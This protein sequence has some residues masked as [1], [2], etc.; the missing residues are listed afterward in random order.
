MCFLFFD[1]PVGPAWTDTRWPLDRAGSDR[2][3]KDCQLTRYSDNRVTM[4]CKSD[5]KAEGPSEDWTA[6]DN[7]ASGPGL[8]SSR[9]ITPK[10]PLF[11]NLD[12]AHQAITSR[13]ATRSAGT[14]PSDTTQPLASSPSSVNVSD[15]TGSAGS[16][17]SARHMELTGSKTNHQVRQRCLTPFSATAS[18][19]ADWHNTPSDPSPIVSSFASSSAGNSIGT[20]LHHGTA[21]ENSANLERSDFEDSMDA[22]YD[23][24]FMPSMSADVRQ[25]RTVSGVPLINDY[26]YHSEA[27]IQ[28]VNFYSPDIRRAN[29]EISLANRAQVYYEPPQRALPKLPEA[30]GNTKHL[31][32]GSGNWPVNFSRPVRSLCSASNSQNLINVSTDTSETSGLGSPVANTGNRSNMIQSTTNNFDPDFVV[33]GRL[34]TQ[35][36]LSTSDDQ[37]FPESDISHGGVSNAEVVSTGTDSDE[38]PFQY[39]RGSF[40]AFLQPAREREVSVAL[41]C[42]SGDSTASASQLFLRS[43][44]ARP[45][46]PRVVG[47]TNPFIN[48]LQGYQAPSVQYNWDDDGDEPNEI[49]ISI[50]SSPPP[51]PPNSPVQPTMN[52]NEFVKE[53]NKRCRKDIMSDGADWETVAATSVGQF[54]SNRAFASSMDLGGGHLIKYAGSS[55]ADYSDTSSYHAPQFDAFGSQ[56]RIVPESGTH[57]APTTRLPRTL[58]EAGQPIF[59]PKPRIHR[60]N[61]YLH[62]SRR[63]FTD[64]TAGSSGNSARSAIVE[65]LSASIRTRT[66]RKQAHRRNL[67]LNEKNQSDSRFQSMESISST[68]SEQ[69]DGDHMIGTALECDPTA[70]SSN[71]ARVNMTVIGRDHRQ[72]DEDKK[73]LLASSIPKEPARAHLKGRIAT[74]PVPLGSPTLFSFPLISLQ[75]AA[76]R[77]AT[78]SANEDNL[79]VTSKNTSMASSKATQRT[80]P[81]TPHIAKPSAAYRPTSAS[82][83]GIS[84]TDRGCSDYSQGV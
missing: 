75:E 66:A 67:Y 23:T 16:L 14:H 13:L 46:S 33:Y 11:P 82:I 15:P 7:P 2:T 68:Y 32:N 21:Q 38:D 71:Q 84:M 74:G 63:M 10:G 58:R 80:T 40:T 39:D 73:A 49:K 31:T 42:V 52:L 37:A 18:S 54:D 77:E 45:A 25:S 24:Y 53:Q 34:P 65:K 57:R 78:R 50:H 47:S 20:Q 64:T 8:P 55:I 83:F 56:E 17:P 60:V 62:N 48:K 36:N 27:R 41:R 19:G 44:S 6:T 28:S 43:P 26:P 79:T 35:P 70:T 51:V 69:P 59:L 12:E 81:P 3:K 5:G 61:G 30:R 76:K 22:I 4:S 9:S 72:G 1:S 29:T